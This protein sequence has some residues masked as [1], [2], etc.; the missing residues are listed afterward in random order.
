MEAISILLPVF[1][2]NLLWLQ[3]QLDSI[4]EQTYSAFRCVVSHDGSLDSFS[5]D[6]INSVLPDD[7]FTLVLG[8]K[9]LGTYKHV[10]YLISEFG[11]KTTFFALCDQDDIWLPNKLESQISRLIHSEVSVVS[12]NGQI[13]NKKLESIRGLTTF[14][15]F[16]ISQRHERF[17]SIRNQITGASAL[18]RSDRFVKCV[19]FPENVDVAIHDHWMYI[20][21]LSTGGA[22]FDVEPLWL[23]RQHERNQIGASAQSGRFS[24]ALKGIQ[25]SRRMLRN[26][27]LL[28]DDSVIR[29]GKIF[30]S[31]AESRWSSDVLKNDVLN[32]KLSRTER[33]RLLRPATL[34]GSSLESLR[35]AISQQK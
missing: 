27:Y 17:A 23:Y 9:H 14:D 29:Q 26:R 2:P 13:V 18:F 34:L 16:G 19:P 12:N 32:C 11:L 28:R 22:F 6:Q 33:I 24:R 5:A 30:L 10:E 21:A 35:V 20:A 1:R 3:E 25:K 4:A 7:R 8:S 31:A 15:W